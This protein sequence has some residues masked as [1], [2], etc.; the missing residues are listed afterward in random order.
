MSEPLRAARPG[1]FVEMSE[2]LARIRGL[3][4]GDTVR[5]RNERGAVEAP[6]LVTARL[7]PFLC[8]GSEAH[9]VVLNG[10]EVVDEV[11]DAGFLPTSVARGWSILAPGAVASAG[12][13]CEHKGFLVDV[14]KA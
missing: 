1:F 8:E 7:K 9:Y 2:E 13:A 12:C 6:V 11:A 14:E 10:M 5:V 4:A 3:A